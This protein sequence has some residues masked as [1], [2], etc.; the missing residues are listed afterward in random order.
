MKCIEAFD[1]FD[2]RAF[3][4]CWIPKSNSSTGFQNSREAR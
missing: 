1:R 4:N 3:F 2:F